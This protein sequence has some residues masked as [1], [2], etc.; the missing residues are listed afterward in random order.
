MS[1]AFDH[2]ARWF[3]GKGRVVTGVSDAGEVAGLRLREVVYEDGG[4]ERYLDVPDGFA[5]APL[6]AELVD[7]P[8]AGRGGRLELRPGPAWA[9]ASGSER[10]VATDQSNTVVVVG[11]ELLVKAY[12]RVEAGAHAE[13]EVLAALAGSGGAP[14]PA[15]A[16]S[17]HWVADAGDDTAIALLQAFVPG[18]E[19][20]WEG[21]VGRIVAALRAGPPYDVSEWRAAGEVTAALHHALVDA[22]G[23]TS[24]GGAD[25]R[26][27]RAEAEAA[28][29]AAAH[30]A[31]AT[32]R[33]R[34]ASLSAIAPPPV[35]RI[36]G[37]LHIAQ[38][39]RAGGALLVIDFE[40]DPVRALADRR[41]LS[42]PLWD[43]ATMLRCL[44][45]LGSAAARRYA[46]EPDAWIA[47]ASE[48]FLEAYT[49]RAPVPVDRDLIGLL[50]LAKE[51]LEL[52]Y[53]QRYLPEWLYA[54]QQGM[55]RLLA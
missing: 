39:L 41:R 52:V 20:G 47:A 29:D 32:I 51:C 55:L 26:G 45:H 3:G 15:F 54:P 17:V 23:L 7:W 2:T 8:L 43:V 31:A 19:D 10:V 14:V 30:P 11:E 9:G 22:F 13:V 6:L 4:G 40:G 25:L 35:T 48:A 38:L 28:L 34:L 5:W 24:D 37:D 12:R 50:E 44:D 33:D 1:E 16:G 53:A 42:T 27:W 21:P 46:P 49:A 36:H 18:V